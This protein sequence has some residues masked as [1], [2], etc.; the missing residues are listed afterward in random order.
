MSVGALGAL[1][2]AEHA[3]TYDG[4]LDRFEDVGVEP[5]AGWGVLRLQQEVGGSGSTVG[6][7]ATGVLRSFDGSTDPLRYEMNEQAFTGGGDFQLKLDGNRY[8]VSGHVGLSYVAG[9]SAAIANVQT[10]SAHY[11][12]RPDQDHVTYDP[13]RTSLFGTSASRAG[14]QD[15]GRALAVG[16]R[17]VGRLAELRAERRRRD[18]AG[19]RHCDVG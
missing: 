9:D 8:D 6:A 13:T 10:A 12:Q 16:R 11:F 18:P 5:M 4:G 14:P 3:R 1:T 17:S 15:R 7:T 2:S 19:R